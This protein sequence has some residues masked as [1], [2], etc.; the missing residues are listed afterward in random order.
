[1]S[2]TP[3]GPWQQPPRQGAW[4]PPQGQWPQQAPPPAQW[5]RS[6]LPPPHASGEYQPQPQ[7]QQPAYPHPPPPKSRSGAGMTLLLIVVG[8][9]VVIAGASF[10]SGT[11]EFLGSRTPVVPVV[12]EPPVEPIPVPE[13]DPDP[14]P[15]PQ[16]PA[17]LKPGLPPAQWPEL[18][19]PDSSDP[20]WMIL[21]QSPLYGVDVPTL[22][23]CPAPELAGSMD[24]LERLATAQMACIQA[25][26]EPAL[27]SLGFSTADIPVYLYSGSGVDTPCGWVEAPALYCSVQGGAIYFGEETLDGASWQE[28]G[29]KD[30]AGHEYGH[31]LQ[32]QAGMFQAEWEI[33]GGNE[34]ARRLELQASCFG[35]AM[36]GQ[37][38]SYEM[39]PELF[40]SIEP[41]L[42]AVIE[43]GIHGSKDSLAY[44]GLRGLY[45]TSLGNCNT[46]TV[47]GDEVD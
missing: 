27:A 28:L 36:I 40:G 20:S 4:P 14:A 17:G 6:S 7:W 33:D 8:A 38:T 39:T 30:M 42:R 9:I 15:E 32:A 21:Q 1:M 12:T 3:Q 5:S 22:E 35:Y 11:L 31:H 23:G 24:D 46:W 25:A 43:D 10:L 26:W 41:Y 19:A 37:D 47:S 13:P 29:V 16:T 44:W 45:S 18:P 2:T 34:S